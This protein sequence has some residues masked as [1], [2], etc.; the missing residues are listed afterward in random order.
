MCPKRSSAPVCHSQEILWHTWSHLQAL[1]WASGKPPAARVF[2]W[3][4][5]LFWPVVVSIPENVDGTFSNHFCRADAI[6][7]IGTYVRGI[8]GVALFESEKAGPP[9]HRYGWCHWCSS[10]RPEY[11]VCN[12]DWTQVCSSTVPSLGSISAL[13]MPFYRQ[14][15][16]RACGACHTRIQSCLHALPHLEHSCTAHQTMDNNNNYNLLSMINN[17]SIEMSSPIRRFG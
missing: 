7:K 9:I 2:T 17:H 6:R 8:S 16:G 4:E 5:F 13:F 12:C 10:N 3:I 11:I 15:R 1:K 14:S